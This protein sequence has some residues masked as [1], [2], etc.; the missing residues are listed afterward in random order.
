MAPSTSLLV[1]APCQ[2]IQ[3]SPT[4]LILR[5]QLTSV[6]WIIV[7]TLVIFQAPL[8]NELVGDLH[9]KGAMQRV[10]TY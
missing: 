5:F 2:Y 10:V 6:I 9:L 4:F 1:S 8:R 7:G 3:I